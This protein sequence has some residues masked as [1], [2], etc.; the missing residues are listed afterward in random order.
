[1]CRHCICRYE[2]LQRW[3]DALA[4]YE[5]KLAAVRPDSEAHMEAVLGKCRCLAAL[6]QWEALFG[7]CRESWARGTPLL[8]QNMAPIAAHAAWQLGDWQ[9]MRQ[10][11][12]V[13]AQ[14]PAN[15]EGPF[16]LAVLDVKNGEYAS[17]AGAHGRAAGA[18]GRC[19]LR[20]PPLKAWRIVLASSAAAS[21]LGQLSSRPCYAP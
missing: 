17:A 21:L 3:P 9:A 20:Y 19:I 2:K 12:D 16:L 5:R 7:V 11:S 18:A 14:L 13:V 6:A 8:R 4:A 15:S 1:M 10:Y